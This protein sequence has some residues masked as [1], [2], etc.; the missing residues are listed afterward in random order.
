VPV[1]VTARHDDNHREAADTGMD[2]L[3]GWF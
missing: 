3:L 2:G 1:N